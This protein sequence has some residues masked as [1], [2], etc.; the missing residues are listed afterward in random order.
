MLLDESIH[1]LWTQKDS[2]RTQMHLFLSFSSLIFSPFLLPFGEW[3]HQKIP[4]INFIWELHLIWVLFKTLS[5]FGWPDITIDGDTST[6][7]TPIGSLKSA[8]HGPVPKSLQCLD[9]YIA[10]LSR[11]QVL[12]GITIPNPELFFF[13][14]RRLWDSIECWWPIRK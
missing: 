1:W 8:V 3:P 13:L 11:Q 14:F 5:P 6:N 12:T 9:I 2:N 4:F 10:V 7:I